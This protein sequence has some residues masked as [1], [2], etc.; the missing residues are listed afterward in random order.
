MH[1]IETRYHGPTNTRGARISATST[2]GHRVFV[3]Y[4]YSVEI[5]DDHAKAVNAL[6]QKLGWQDKPMHLAGSSKKGYI[7]AFDF[8]VE[9]TYSYHI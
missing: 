6:R 2:E 5:L 7:W 8:L 9:P 1:T 4:D 3:P